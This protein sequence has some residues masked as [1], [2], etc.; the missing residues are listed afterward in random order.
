MP[1]PR[2]LAGSLDSHPGR[3]WSPC[4]RAA[5]SGFRRVLVIGQ[6]SGPANPGTARGLIGDLAAATDL[7]SAIQHIGKAAAA[8]I[9]NGH[10]ASVVSNV[11]SQHV[12][13]I[14][15]DSES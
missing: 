4:G 12:G 7:F 8:R 3:H 9:V 5:R 2:G 6:R 15:L 11:E 1:G 14:D 10:A 13:D